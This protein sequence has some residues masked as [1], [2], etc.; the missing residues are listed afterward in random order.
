MSIKK[1]KS[2]NSQVFTLVCNRL[3][4]HR[5]EKTIFYRLLGFLLR[6]DKPF[7]YSAKSLS[8]VTGYSR[9]S[10][11]ESLNLLEKYRLIKRI[12]YTNQCKFTKG[13]ILKRICTLVQNR[14]NNEQTKSCTL[15]QFL[16][17]LI[18]TSPVSGYKK[19]SLSLKHK[20]KAPS[21]EY[22]EYHSIKKAEIMLGRLPSDFRIISET[23]FLHNLCA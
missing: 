23:E 6:N 22:Q 14:I 15:V 3:K 11:F 4:L 20:E 1:A 2:F 8:E 13:S 12:G 5:R 16:D 21:Q 10:I 18:P 19:T 9:S 17:E 7:P